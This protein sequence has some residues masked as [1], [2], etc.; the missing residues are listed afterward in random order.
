M[1]LSENTQQSRRLPPLEAWKQPDHWLDLRSGRV[2]QDVNKLVLPI[3]HRGIVI[4]DESVEY[5]LDTFFWPDY[6]W[7][8]KA[9]DAQTALDEHH[10]LH[11]AALYKPT[12]FKGN[13]IPQKTRELPTLI[14][15]MPRQL[16]CTFHDLTLEPPVPS[17][18]A[19]QQY[20]SSY[21]LASRAFSRL[22]KSAK[23]VSYASQLFTLRDES[24]KLGRITPKTLDDQ[25][26]REMMIDFFRRH[27]E[28][29][30]RAVDTVRSVG[31]SDLNIPLS[32]YQLLERPHLVVKKLGRFASWSH[33]DYT[34]LLRAA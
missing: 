18:E 22:I 26:G 27:F 14:G 28:E 31:L 10:F 9:G 17:L 13:T 21:Q 4:P 2:K 24:I 30:A 29:Y 8:Y 5:V 16:H 15:L 33:I 32:D 20:F 23:N 7:D 1:R 11:R 25:V 19:M 34:P 6:E 3:D 12:N